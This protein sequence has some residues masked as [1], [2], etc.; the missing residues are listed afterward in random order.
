MVSLEVAAILLSGIGISASLV[1][2]AN[3]LRNANKTR[4]RELIIQRSQTYSLEYMRTMNDVFN[5][6]DWED[7]EEWERKYGRYTNPEENAKWTYIM[8]NYTLAGLL[9]R[10]GADP[11]LPFELYPYSS[12]IGLWETFKPVV[13]YLRERTNDPSIY[14]PFEYL[15]KEAKKRKPDYAPYSPKSRD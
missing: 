2:Y 11:D 12:V 14:E 13:Q 6:L 3:I 7:A 8:R 9:L 4:Q 1:Y 10:Q 15:Y 5:Q